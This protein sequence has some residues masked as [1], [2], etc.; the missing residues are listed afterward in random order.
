MVATR[1]LDDRVRTHDT[2]TGFGA[3]HRLVFQTAA[4]EEFRRRKKG[5][6]VV[7]FDPMLRNVQQFDRQRFAWSRV[8]KTSEPEIVQRA[9]DLE[10]RDELA[11]TEINTRSSGPGDGGAGLPLWRRR[12][13]QVAI[14]LYIYFCLYVGYAKFRG[15]IG[16]SQKPEPI[17]PVVDMFEAGLQNGAAPRRVQ[18]RIVT[19]QT[20]GIQC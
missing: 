18:V 5:S 13:R 20:W 9:R 4:S 8:R 7:W 6:H 12:G 15:M 16:K 19:L 17:Q 3:R 1:R 2:L 14:G 10:D 11:W